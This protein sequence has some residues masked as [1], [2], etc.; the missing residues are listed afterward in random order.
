MALSRWKLTGFPPQRR[1]G[2]QPTASGRIDVSIYTSFEEARAVWRDLEARGS[3]FLF[4]SYDWCS[5][6]FETIGQRLGIEPCLVYACDPGA[7]AELFL[8][9]GVHRRRRTV[10]C[11][12]FLGG[13]LADHT[14]PILVGAT[15]QIRDGAWLS[16]ILD[17]V[18]RV[19]RFDVV[20][21]RHLRGDVNGRPNPLVGSGCTRVGYQTHSLTIA[22]SWHAYCQRQ[23]NS[24][25]QAES[26]R[27]WRRLKEHGAPSF[28]I[29][30]TVDSALA[31]TEVM[32]IQKSRRLRETG[33]FD[34]FALPEYR[35]YC[36]QATRDHHQS[37]MIHVSA[38][39]LD[40]RVLA[41][42]WGAI[43]RN[44]FLSLFSSFEDGDWLKFGLGRLI[45]ECLLEWSFANG[46]AAFDLTIGDEPYKH[47]YCS[48][49]EDLYRLVRPRS[50]LG[51]AYY[52]HSRLVA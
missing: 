45:L 29:A 26:R 50:P 12:E 7:Q 22:G 46:L 40:D 37:K 14:A 8:P 27:R 10:R 49:S 31:I 28:E 32:F 9:L 4:Q 43:W 36:L 6:W 5:M 44:R 15:S 41:T 33:A 39:M 47:K 48:V 11:L 42:H 2:Q 18:R 23:L 19:V 30:R 25:H 51:W 21:L 3:C 34:L 52:A 17:R 38:L 13:R 35:D 24:K 20:D 1:L 16:A